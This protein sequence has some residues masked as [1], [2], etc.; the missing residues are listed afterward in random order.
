MTSTFLSLDI[1]EEISKE[2]S[3][4]GR[5]INPAKLTGEKRLRFFGTGITGYSAWTIDKKPIRW[6][7]KP[8]ELPSNLAPDLSGKISLKRFMAGIV[9]DY[10]AGDFKILEITQRTLYGSALQ[11][12]EGRGLRRPHR[13]RHQDQQD[14]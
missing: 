1:V 14:R 12:H 11:V 7:A 3:S 9:Y 8:A 5:Y 6:E 10:E 13:L 4:N 2:S